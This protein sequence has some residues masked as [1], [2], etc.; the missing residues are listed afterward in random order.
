MSELIVLPSLVGI[1]QDRI[2]FACFLE[3]LLGFLISRV[4]IRMI[5]LRKSPVCFFY[6]IFIGAFIDAE[7]FIVVPF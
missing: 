4:H 5:F 3:L 7:D 6:L 2:G 1:G